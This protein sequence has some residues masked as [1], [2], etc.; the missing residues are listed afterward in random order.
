MD[1]FL[2]SVAR[3][4]ARRTLHHFSSWGMG[5]PLQRR[6]APPMGGSGI[7]GRGRYALCFS[8]SA[9]SSICFAWARSETF[10]NGR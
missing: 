3:S 5:A 10:M 2:S 4:V 9:A 7:E 8:A 1:H 6:E